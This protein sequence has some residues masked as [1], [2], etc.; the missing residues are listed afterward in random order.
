M[1]KQTQGVNIAHCSRCGLKHARPVG[2]RCKTNLNVSAPAFTDGLGEEQQQHQGSNLHPA[3]SNIVMTES[4]ATK[5]P[6]SQVESKLHL[7]LQ[8]MHE[9]ENKNSRLEKRLDEQSMSAG[10]KPQPVH[11]SPKRSLR[12]SARG[13]SCFHRKR[14]MVSTSKQVTGDDSSDEDLTDFSHPR[15]S[16]TQMS[17]LSDHETSKEMPSLQFLKEDEKIQKK[18]Q[19]QLERLQGQ[20]RG[21]TSSGK[22]TIKSDVTSARGEDKTRLKNFELGTQLGLS[23]RRMEPRLKLQRHPP[24]TRRVTTSTPILANSPRTMWST[25]TS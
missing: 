1:S 20:P 4:S 6:A 8:K 9:L 17:A 10:S 22:K 21:T 7:I 14:R 16:S 11:S 19:K 3:G 13:D 2:A 15:A 23:V 24:R 12:C 5:D 25:D 18:V